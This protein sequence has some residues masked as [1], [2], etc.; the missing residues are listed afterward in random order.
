MGLR[1]LKRN[2]LRVTAEMAIAEHQRHVVV[3]RAEVETGSAVNRDDRVGARPSRRP[4]E[5]ASAVGYGD[6]PALLR[7]E[8]RRQ[9]EKCEPQF[10]LH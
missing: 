1:R 4:I 5:E 8:R 10:D 2:S 7:R 9:R 3:D 6:V